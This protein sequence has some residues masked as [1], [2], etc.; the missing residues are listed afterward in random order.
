M[1]LGKEM[2]ALRESNTNL[3]DFE[4]CK[5]IA[6]GKIRGEWMD[7]NDYENAKKATDETATQILNEIDSNRISSYNF[8]KLFD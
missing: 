8:D 3:S 5:L 2:K 6:S 7:K 1:D 4:I